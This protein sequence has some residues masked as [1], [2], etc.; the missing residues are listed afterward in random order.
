MLSLEEYIAKRKREDKVNEF[1]IDSKTDNLRIC[2]NYVFEYFNQYLNIDQMEQKTFLN[3]ER[4]EKFKKQLEVYDNEIQEWLVDIYDVH[5]KQIHRSII[6]YLKKD[7]LFLLYHT[8]NEFRSCSYDCYAQLV[9]KNPFLKDQTEMLFLFIKDYHRIESQ[10]DIYKPSVFLTEDINEWLEKTWNKHRVNIWAFASNYIERFSDDDSL[11]PAKH[12]IKN[13]ENWQPYVY[14]YKQK[15]NL[16]NLNTL[17]P[18]ISKKPFIKGMKQHLEIIMMYIWLHE[19]WGD[20][21]NYWEDYFT[22]TFDS[23][24]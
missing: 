21:D 6:N 11:W 1:D 24:K 22:K 10:R 8:E 2:V 20:E 17:Y 13:K 5:E 7:E 12:K 18:R 23:L 4:L 16:F 9:K 3:E 14:D 19:I 15:T